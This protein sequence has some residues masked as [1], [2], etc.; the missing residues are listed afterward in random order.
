MRRLVA[1]DAWRST[2]ARN[3]WSDLYLDGV[4]FEQFVLAEQARVA[5]ILRRIHA[6]DQSAG[7]GPPQVHARTGG[8]PETRRSDPDR[9]S[10]SADCF[11]P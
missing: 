9:A 6:D 5:G 3:G 7:G 11:G 2:L 10:S 1:T 4:A 8:G